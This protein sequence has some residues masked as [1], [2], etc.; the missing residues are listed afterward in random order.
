MDCFVTEH[1]LSI[2]IPGDY[3]WE[4]GTALDFTNWDPSESI[5]RQTD[6]L[7]KDSD[8][9]C[10][11]VTPQGT[12]KQKACTGTSNYF[13]CQIK[14]IYTGQQPT[15]GPN[16]GGPNTGDPNQPTTHSSIGSQKSSPKVL[17]GG[18]KAGIAFSVI[19]G[20]AVVLVIG[21]LA[22]KKYRPNSSVA[23]FGNSLYR[24]SRANKR[25]SHDTPVAWNRES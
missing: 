12:W 20:V 2:L 9:Q 22:I 15:G 19:A 4:D 1:Y 11:E 7:N 10:V 14:K 17:S 24:S 25:D 16:T 23:S 18:A 8:R 13:I 3:Q 5:I 6:D 21:F